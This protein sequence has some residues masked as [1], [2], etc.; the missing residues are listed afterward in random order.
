MSD[1]YLAFISTLVFPFFL[2]MSKSLHPNA[3][4]T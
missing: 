3:K 2:K 1:L 4:S